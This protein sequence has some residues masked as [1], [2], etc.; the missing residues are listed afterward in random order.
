[1]LLGLYL[2]GAVFRRPWCRLC[3]SGAMLS[4]F[5]SWSLLSKEKDV[6]KCTKCGVCARVCLMDNKNVYLEKKSKDISSTNCIR[7]F[8]CLES[9][10]EDGCLSLKFFGKT[11]YK[12]GSKM[13]RKRKA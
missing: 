9:C 10:P 2:S 13:K 1:V 4:L 6:R 8:R 3:P 5:D 7:C 11:I 12:S